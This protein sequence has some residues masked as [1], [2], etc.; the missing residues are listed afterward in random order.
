MSFVDENGNRQREPASVNWDEA[1]SML[2]AKITSIKER[3]DLKPGEV[4]ACRDSFADVADKFLAYQ[5]A[6]LT[7]KAYKRE[8]GIMTKEPPQNNLNNFHAFGDCF[9]GR[10]V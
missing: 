9:L 8:D 10:M 3:K 2:A 1:H 5:E 7:E 6:R 4:P